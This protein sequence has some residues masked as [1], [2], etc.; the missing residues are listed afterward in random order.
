MEM[1]MEAYCP[2]G[3]THYEHKCFIFIN[4]FK[5]WIEAEYYCVFVGGNLASIHSYEQNHFLRSLTEDGT[6]SFPL[7]WIG[8]NDA[9]HQTAWLWSDGSK[10]D[11]E[12]WTRYEQLNELDR[13]CLQ[14]NYGLDKKWTNGV[15]NNPLPFICG[16]M[17]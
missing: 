2:Y 4:S 12:N 6:N 17:M 14:M 11:Y 8:A 1:E 10:C 15:C 16:K 13:R 7:T 9:V 3:W 5:T